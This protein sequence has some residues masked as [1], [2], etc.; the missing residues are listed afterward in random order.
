M[1]MLIPDF[2]LTFGRESFAGK[3]KWT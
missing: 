2:T 3:F 1:E